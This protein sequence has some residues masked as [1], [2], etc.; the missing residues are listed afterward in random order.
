MIKK[1]LCDPNTIIKIEMEPDI[2]YSTRVDIYDKDG[3]VRTIPTNLYNTA[4]N[5][6]TLSLSPSLNISKNTH[7]DGYNV[8]VFLTPL[9]VFNNYSLVS[10][11]ENIKNF[12]NI[13]AI[14]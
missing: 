13:I 14:L 3:I 9:N 10:K 11:T 1:Y 8:V 12:K 7:I 6:A 5:Q 2:L 4:G